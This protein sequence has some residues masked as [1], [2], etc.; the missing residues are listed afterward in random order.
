MAFRAD[1]K[2]S[3]ELPVGAG[4]HTAE[5]SRI[6][7]G[8]HET[9]ECVAAGE[10]YLAGAKLGQSIEA[11]DAGIDRAGDAAGRI[12]QGLIGPEG[13]SRGSDRSR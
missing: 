5:Q 11:G 2:I 12:E 3:G 6:V 1:N 8:E 4:L 9:V 10:R 13:E 7:I